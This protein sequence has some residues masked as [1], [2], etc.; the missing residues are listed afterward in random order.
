MFLNHRST[1]GLKIHLAL[2]GHFFIPLVAAIT[3]LA[4]LMIAGNYA[5]KTL[6]NRWSAGAAS[7]VILQIPETGNQDSSS[8]T[9]PASGNPSPSSTQQDPVTKIISLLATSQELSSFHKL[10]NNE[11]NALLTPWLHQDFRSLALSIPA[12][13]ELHLKNETTLSSQL[14]NSLRQI[15][16]NIMIEQSNFWNQRL[17]TLA[18]SL[19][20]C[21]FLALTTVIFVAAA[22]IAVITRTGLV[23][24]KQTITILYNLGATDHYI[25]TRFARRNAFLAMIGGVVGSFLSMPM[26]LFLTYLSLPFNSDPNWQMAYQKWFSF[27]ALLPFNLF[28][29]LLFLP[30][31]N[32]CI[33]WLTTTV[34]VRFWLR[35]ML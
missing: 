12:I 35:H 33:G 16:P 7:T 27:I 6:A 3:F 22:I 20:T 34:I 29:L 28:L 32:Y 13:I 17:N 14:S 21:A 24:C 23:Q 11:I 10:D 4:A 15:S 25:S 9:I 1:D 30:L 26:L 2:S 19:Q 8:P 5:A 18:N 31:F